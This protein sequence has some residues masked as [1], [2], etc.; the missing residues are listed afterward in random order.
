MSINELLLRYI[1]FAE[2][3]YVKDGKPTKELVCMKEAM[4]PLRTLFGELSAQE[5]GPLK[6][7]AVRQ[8][9]IDAGLSRGV[10]NQRVNRIKRIL[11]WGV[12]E[13]LLP[14]A[15]H[16][17]VRTVAGLRFGR[18]AARETEPVGPV[19]DQWVD[20]V[21]LHVAPQVATMIELQRFTGMRP[22]EVV[23]M[24]PCDIDRTND[25][26]LYEPYDHKNRWRGHRRR[27]PLGPKAQTLIQPFLNR[28]GDDFLFSPQEAEGHRNTQRAVHRDPN[29][30]TKIYPCELR[31]QEARKV[32]SRSRR[33]KRPK[34]QRYT[35]D[36]Y[37]RAI[38]YGIA[39]ANRS[40]RKAVPAKMEVPSWHPN[41]LRHSFATRVRKDFG[42]EAAQVGLGHARTDV[43]EV[44]AEKNLELAAKVA[45][46]TG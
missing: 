30:K 22:G 19:A 25:V 38:A 40:H 45:R 43:V 5:F 17:G 39:Q 31:A 10:I 35:S 21:V 27:I 28:P 44:Y 9:M 42:V 14:A 1:E 36:S 26:W 7:K 24:R 32:Q 16:E 3:Y 13:E 4:R 8:H 15:V 23:K 12:S 34:G 11:K 29:R 33:S 41:Q 2:R 6:L 20:A 46:L 18:S 37:R